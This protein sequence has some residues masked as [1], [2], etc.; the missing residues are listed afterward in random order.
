MKHISCIAFTLAAFALAGS[1]AFAQGTSTQTTTSTITSPQTTPQTAEQREKA[2]LE[3]EAVKKTLAAH[4]ATVDQARKDIERAQTDG[5]RARKLAQQE[6]NKDV[7]AEIA[8]VQEA[9]KEAQREIELYAKGTAALDTARYEKAL[10]AFAEAAALKGLKADSA[11]YWKAFSEYKI[12]AMQAALESLKGIQKNFPDSRWLEQ[13]LALELEVKGA[14]G[15]PVSP[16]ATPDEELKLLALNSLLDTDADQALPM[17]EKMINGQQSVRLKKRALF[18]LSQSKSPKAREV[19]ASVA[20]G[21]SDP[22]LQLEALVY[23]QMF[24]GAEEKKLLADVY[25]SSKD[26]DVKVR[27]ID[28]LSTQGDARTLVDMARKET[29]PAMRKRIVERLSRMKAKEATDYMLE[30]INK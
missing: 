18:V 25:S 30:I 22:E 16:G 17:L 10:E 5:E 6:A 19:L 1:A 2:R 13:A 26:R 4:Q 21:S 24:G 11:L 8:K 9:L 7:T 28:A 3:A 14:M 27:V 23:L 15:K 29:D 12:Q 20:K